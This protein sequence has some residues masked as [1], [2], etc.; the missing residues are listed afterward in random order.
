MNRP[1]VPVL[2]YHSVSARPARATRRLSVDPG[3]FAEQMALLVERGFVA[4]PVSALAG[5]PARLPAK[6]VAI[7]FDDGYADFHEQALP[8]LQRLGLTAT[9]FVTTGWLADAGAEAAGRPLDRTLSWSQVREA[10]ECGIEIGGHSH[11]HPQLDQLPDAALAHELTC[12]KALLEDRLGRPVTTMAYPYGYSSARVRRAVARAGYASACAVANRLPRREDVFAT[13]R[14]TVSRG[15]GIDAFAKV[16][17]G[18]ALLRTYAFDRMLTKG[19][20]VVRR[21]RYAARQVG[22]ARA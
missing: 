17:E 6:A 7:T 12:S 1:P 3:A 4:V 5:D 15:M 2:M 14:L 22:A 21:L 13:P 16:V 10:A 11:S 8:V 18:G 20:A 19:Y 9:V